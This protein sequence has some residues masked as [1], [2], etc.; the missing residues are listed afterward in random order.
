M[1][2]ELIDRLAQRTPRLTELDH[3]SLK[4]AE[5]AL[6]ES[7][8]FLVVSQEIMP[9]WVLDKDMVTQVFSAT[10]LSTTYLA[11]HLRISK[12]HNSVL[13]TCERNIQSSRVV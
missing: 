9:K 3:A 5:R 6:H 1:P 8:L 7:V 10:K 12:D 2:S 13:R 11:E 4:V